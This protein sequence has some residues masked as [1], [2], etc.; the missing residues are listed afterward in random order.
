MKDVP[1]PLVDP[2][3][4]HCYRCGREI[5]RIIDIQSDVDGNPY[6]MSVVCP[7]CGSFAIEYEPDEG[8]R[9]KG[10]SVPYIVGA[11][12]D[13]AY[14]YATFDE[15]S[16]TSKEEALRSKIELLKELISECGESEV[17]TPEG[18]FDAELEEA[19]KESYELGMEEYIPNYAEHILAGGSFQ[20]PES[21]SE[22]GA[23]L[24][25]ISCASAPDLAILYYLSVFSG[26]DELLVPIMDRLSVL[27]EEFDDLDLEE[28]VSRF[29]V[30]LPIY[31][32]NDKIDRA[33]EIYHSIL[34][35]A[36]NSD[37]DDAVAMV[38]Y[39][40]SGICESLPDGDMDGMMAGVRGLRE[41]FPFDFMLCALE[42]ARRFID[43]PER[44]EGIASD[45]GW[46]RDNYLGVLKEIDEGEGLDYVSAI[47]YFTAVLSGSASGM[48]VAIKAMMSR[49]NG[50]DSFTSWIIADYRTNRNPKRGMAAWIDR[51]LSRLGLDMDDIEE[52]A[53]EFDYP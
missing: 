53:A 26:R 15:S 48:S 5:G 46:L 27:D 18:R 37:S 23:V 4:L 33:V 45:L 1:A 12:S 42:N 34:E 49:F 2:S 51:T 39:L 32:A 17:S 13:T 43:N 21:D 50:A 29:A 28:S 30:L 10:T 6:E 52:S 47:G 40:H 11:F 24:K 25:G 36:V 20:T 16:Y 44:S 31:Q 9:V 19:L 8:W 3:F 22:T 7:S 38:A 14:C 41:A 35:K